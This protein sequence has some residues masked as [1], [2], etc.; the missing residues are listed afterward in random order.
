SSL[1][2]ISL[3]PVVSQ[4]L[5][6]KIIRSEVLGIPWTYLALCLPIAMVLMIIDNVR[7]I[8]LNLRELFFREPYKMEERPWR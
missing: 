4:A 6:Y 2:I 1:L 5:W 8:F 3:K 7:F